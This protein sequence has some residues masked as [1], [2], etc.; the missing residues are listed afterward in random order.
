MGAAFKTNTLAV[1]DMFVPVI[2]VL[3]PAESGV[4]PPK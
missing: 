4:K 3:S 1:N 2:P